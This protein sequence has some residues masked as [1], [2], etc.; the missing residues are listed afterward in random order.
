MKYFQK[1]N[2]DTKVDE[3]A[4]KMYYHDEYNTIQELDQLTSDNFSA[5]LKQF[6]AS[7]KYFWSRKKTDFD[8]N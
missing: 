5:R 8:A 4:S 3:I 6:L 1:T 7:K 2:Y